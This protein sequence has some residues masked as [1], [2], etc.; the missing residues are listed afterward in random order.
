V[1]P[2][3]GLG[4][5]EVILHRGSVVLVDLEPTRGHEQRGTRP[6]LVVSDPAVAAAQRFPLICVVPLTTAPGH[7]VLYPS[8]A[9]GKSGLKR[10]SHALL[11]QIRSIDKRRVLR[12][13]GTI[14]ADE[15]A[16][17]DEGLLL[18][19]GLA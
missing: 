2:R 5:S 15:L 4:A 1:V 9:A 11:E 14:T 10:P 8:L 17:V 3:Q 6:C 13:Y 18:Y 12:I 7:G 19:L 16:A